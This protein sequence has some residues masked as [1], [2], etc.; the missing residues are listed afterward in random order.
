ML[1]AIINTVKSKAS[2]IYIRFFY[3]IFFNAQDNN[4]SF[5]VVGQLGRGRSYVE[6]YLGTPKFKISRKFF[7]NSTAVQN[8]LLN[9]TG[10]VV[11]TERMLLKAPLD[12]VL[13]VPD[14]VWLNIPLPATFDDYRNNLPKSARSDLSRIKREGYTY[15]ISNDVTWVATFFKKYHMPA[16]QQRHNTNAYITE[17]NEL[18]AQ[19]SQKG[20]EFINVYLNDVCVASMLTMLKGREYTLSQMGWLNGDAALVHSGAVAALYW[21]AIKRAFDLGCNQIILGGTPAHIDNGVLVF[22]AKW[23][24]R[25]SKEKFHDINYLLLNPDNINCYNF[26]TKVSLIAIGRDKKLIL[27]TRKKPEE[28]KIKD[29]ILKDISLW[30]VLRE[31][32]ADLPCDGLPPILGAWYDKLPI[33]LT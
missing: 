21:Y 8:S 18:A 28:L 9:K 26:L 2:R 4:L 33:V 13:A 11:I 22:K 7:F 10:L 5:A 6:Q 19:I 32:K 20:S 23:G 16:M 29:S 31:S 1:N 14:L 17:I 25:I 12:E 24:A 30:Y 27:L 15:L 3:G